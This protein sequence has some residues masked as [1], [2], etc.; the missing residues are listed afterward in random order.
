M[1]DIESQKTAGTKPSEPAT[2]DTGAP[3]DAGSRV[4]PSERPVQSARR[5]WETTLSKFP[6]LEPKDWKENYG[7][8]SKLTSTP[9]L[10]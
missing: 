1:S 9:W 3:T 10:C 2:E 8:R 4:Y 5:R 6:G 7:L